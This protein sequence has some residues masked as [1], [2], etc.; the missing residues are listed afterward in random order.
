MPWHMKNL[1]MHVLFDQGAIGLILLSVLIFMAFFRLTVKGARHHPLAPALAG[2]LAG[3]IVVGMFDS[4][5]D[6]P[7]LSLLFYFLLMVS[8]VIRTASND[9]RAGSLTHARR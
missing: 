9:G 7:R 4:L 8:L 6:V 2:G 3:F 5:L 1:F